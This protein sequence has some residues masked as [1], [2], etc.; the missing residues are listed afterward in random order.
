MSEDNKNKEQG[1]SINQGQTKTGMSPQAS[2][3]GQTISSL[4]S[5]GPKPTMRP[6]TEG[7]SLHN[8]IRKHE[9]EG[10]TEYRGKSK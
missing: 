7:F 8:G 9:E 2:L 6:I 4:L 1:S 10:L 5:N 3:G